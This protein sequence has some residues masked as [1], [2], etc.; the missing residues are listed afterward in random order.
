MV[1]LSLFRLKGRRIL[2]DRL[3]FVIA[4]YSQ[5]GSISVLEETRL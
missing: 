5:S 1:L 3:T 4:F 2:G